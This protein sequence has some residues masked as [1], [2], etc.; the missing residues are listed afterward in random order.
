MNT[1]DWLII[2]ILLFFTLYGYFH[3]F[4]SILIQLAGIILAFYL[5][6]LVSKS[7]HLSFP[8]VSIVSGVVFFLT[9]TFFIILA[10]IVGKIGHLF[11]LS[12]FFSGVFGFMTGLT[13]SCYVILFSYQYFPQT[14]NAINHSFLAKGIADLMYKKY[15]GT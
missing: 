11:P 15:F 13:F 3:G 2:V 8:W 1:Y 4:L 12:K 7:F 9:L 5:S 6:S 10:R 14:R